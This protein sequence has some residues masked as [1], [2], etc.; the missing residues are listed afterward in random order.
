MSPQLDDEGAGE[1]PGSPAGDGLGLVGVESSA[2]TQGQA[3]PLSA[4]DA[5][6]LADALDVTT[7]A[8]SSSA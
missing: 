1:R 5:P 6:L 3:A 4:D 2:P 7:T 8:L